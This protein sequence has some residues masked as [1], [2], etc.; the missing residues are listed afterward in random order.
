MLMRKMAPDAIVIAIVIFA[1][2]VSLAKTFARRNNYVID[3][4]QVLSKIHVGCFIWI[5]DRLLFLFNPGRVKMG[6][7]LKLIIT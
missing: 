4:N 2:N 7:W 3:S 6:Y 5:S 1:T